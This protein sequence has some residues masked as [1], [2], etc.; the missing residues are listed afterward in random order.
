MTAY[1]VFA[2]LYDKM[3]DN[4]PYEEWEQY[5]L[6]LMY[7]AGVSAAAAVTEIGCGTGTMTG[8]LYEEGFKVAGLDLSEDMLQEARRK[9]WKPPEIFST[10]NT[11]RL[12]G[13]RKH[14]SGRC[15]PAPP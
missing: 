7:K 12:Q 6:M 9:P 4:I 14:P 10:W 3:M 2:K 15:H 13:S 5:L 8:L 1:S 11:V